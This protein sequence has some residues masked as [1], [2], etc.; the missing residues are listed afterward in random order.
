VIEN[1]SANRSHEILGA[2]QLDERPKWADYRMLFS[3]A[4]R[5]G[6]IDASRPISPFSKVS[7]GSV[8]DRSGK[9]PAKGNS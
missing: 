8:A 7:A 3:P 5:P 2:R 6:T 4:R 1:L 9:L